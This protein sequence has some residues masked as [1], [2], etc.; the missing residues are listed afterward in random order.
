MQS[1][2][3][4]SVIARNLLLS[5][6]S[7]PGATNVAAPFETN[8]LPASLEDTERD[9]DLTTLVS[10][11]QRVRITLFNG[12]QLKG[13][14]LAVEPHRLYLA[15]GNTFDFTTWRKVEIWVPAD[16]IAE[17]RAVSA[18]CG[19]NPPKQVDWDKVGKVSLEVAEVILYTAVMA[20][21]AYAGG[22]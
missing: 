22:H 4:K 21:A 7:L 12:R 19:R 20:A 13:R 11:R 14:T 3:T 9:P 17:L 5:V 6:L 8:S 16:E 2:T 10:A 15:L 18:P 1:L